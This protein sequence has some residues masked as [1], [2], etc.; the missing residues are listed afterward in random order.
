[1]MGLTPRE[2]RRRF[3]AVL[4]FAE[5]EDFAEMKLKNY[6]SGMMV[7]LGFSL[8]T[9]VDAD[10]FLIDEVLAVGD[11]AFQQ[12]CFDAFGAPAPG[13]EDDRARHPRHGRGAEPLRP[14][15]AA[16]GRRTSREIGQPRRHRPRLP[17]GQLREATRVVAPRGQ[18]LARR[19]GRDRVPRRHGGRRGERDGGGPNLAEPARRCGIEAEVEAVGSIEK[20]VFAFTIATVDGQMIFGTR[21]RSRV[22]DGDW[23][24]AASGPGSRRDRQPARPGPLLRP[25]RRR[26]RRARARGDRSSARTPPTSS[27][28]APRSSSAS[29]SSSTRRARRSRAG[30]ER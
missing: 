6:S 24:A 8:M 13:G 17:A 28:T 26:P 16:R 30:G 7:R 19:E 3:D 15:D 21:R 2:A 10:V 12:K 23:L 18:L 9:Q 1:M 14:G 22:G 5:L 29:S 25:P 4:A 11:A 27:S 20:P